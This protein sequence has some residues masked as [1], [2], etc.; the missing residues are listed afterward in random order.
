MSPGTR[1]E[2]RSLTEN[3]LHI[4]KRKIQSHVQKEWKKF[5]YKISDLFWLTSFT[6]FVQTL[7]GKMV[8]DTCTSRWY[9]PSLYT[10][11]TAMKR[12]L[13]SECSCISDLTGQ[14]IP[15]QQLQHQSINC[16]VTVAMSWNTCILIWFTG[17]V[18]E[19][20]SDWVHVPARQESCQMWAQ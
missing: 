7:F 10:V 12:C 9:D 19:G 15:L 6:S 1:S 4:I 3:M 5:V 8:V 2:N 13:C 20:W 17:M 18:C 14:V 16:I 11:H